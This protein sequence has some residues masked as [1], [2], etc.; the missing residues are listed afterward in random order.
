MFTARTSHRTTTAHDSVQ[1][2]LR[3]FYSTRQM[4]N[5]HLLCEIL[6]RAYWPETVVRDIEPQTEGRH[7][8]AKLGS[9]ELGSPDNSGMIRPDRSA[10]CLCHNTH[11]YLA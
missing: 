5:P 9:A 11:P 6:H 7:S 4:H 8:L 10:S 2:G 3:A 1:D